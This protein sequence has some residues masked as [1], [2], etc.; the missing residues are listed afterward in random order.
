MLTK[1]SRP[2]GREKLY[3]WVVLGSGWTYQTPLSIHLDAQDNRG[4]PIHDEAQRQKNGPYKY[5]RSILVIRL[6]QRACLGPEYISLWTR[7]F[8]NSV[9]SL[10][11]SILVK[12]SG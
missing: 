9:F 2:G 11:F 6:Q 12:F 1:R 5:G 3:H 4:K 7:N 10:Y 8:S